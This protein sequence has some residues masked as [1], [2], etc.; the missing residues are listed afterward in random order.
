[1]ETDW[2]TILAEIKIF[3]KG[4]KTTYSNNNILKCKGF[5]NS[6]Y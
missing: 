6:T 4:I 3:S 1:M 2:T 5:W